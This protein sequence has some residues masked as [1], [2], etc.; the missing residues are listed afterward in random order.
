MGADV[1]GTLIRKDTPIVTIAKGMAGEENGLA[2][3]PDILRQG[4]LESYRSDIHI[5]AIGGPA[6]GTFRW[7]A[8]SVEG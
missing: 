5:A 8:G 1:L 6:A 4:L 2:L 7:G 3:L